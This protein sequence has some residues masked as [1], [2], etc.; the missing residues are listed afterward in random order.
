MAAILLMHAE[1]VDGAE[2]L[3]LVAEDVAMH[4]HLLG[5]CPC[6]SRLNSGGRWRCHTREDAGFGSAADLGHHLA[7]AEQFGLTVHCSHE[8]LLHALDQ[9]VVAS[10]RLVALGGMVHATISLALL[11]ASVL[12]RLRLRLNVRW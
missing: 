5:G 12:E 7:H 10:S 6:R 1:F 2:Q 9:V 4:L 3:A 8:P 11:A